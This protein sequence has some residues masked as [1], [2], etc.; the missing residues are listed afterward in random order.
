[1]NSQSNL[2]AGIVLVAGFAAM[3]DDSKRC[4]RPSVIDFKRIARHWLVCQMNSLLE[5]P[6]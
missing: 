1:M 3:I 4:L 6:G 2:T 5:C